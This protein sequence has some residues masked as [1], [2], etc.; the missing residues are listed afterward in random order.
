M[1]SSSTLI[2]K[3]PVPIPE[4]STIWI[5]WGLKNLF[6]YRKEIRAKRG[7]VKQVR[8]VPN[9]VGSPGESATTANKILI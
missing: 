2:Q 7:V 4:V 3:I 6:A 5:D 1:R 9:T 8:F